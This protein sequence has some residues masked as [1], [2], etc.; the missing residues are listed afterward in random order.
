MRGLGKDCERREWS[1]EEEGYR[2]CL[3]GGAGETVGQRGG[4]MMACVWSTEK[5]SK[6]YMKATEHSQS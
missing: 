4:G 3:G 6:G 5:R 1:S 2:S